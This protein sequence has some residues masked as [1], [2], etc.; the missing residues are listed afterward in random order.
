MRRQVGATGGS[1]G[2]QPGNGCKLGPVG[3]S[4]FQHLDGARDDGEQV[5]EVMNNDA[6]EMAD[7]RHPLSL[8]VRRLRGVRREGLLK[9][10]SGIPRRRLSP[11]RTRYLS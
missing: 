11:R 10:N 1:P 8:T 7:D 6:G 2:D 4:L 5:V 9:H 3:D